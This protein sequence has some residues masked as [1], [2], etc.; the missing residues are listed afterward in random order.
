[1]EKLDHEYKVL[2]H[3]H[4]ESGGHHYPNGLTHKTFPNLVLE[5]CSPWIEQDFSNGVKQKLMR[6]TAGP[7]RDIHLSAPTTIVYQYHQRKQD[8]RKAVELAFHIR[9]L[10]GFCRLFHL[11]QN[12]MD[13]LV[14]ESSPSLKMLQLAE[15][16][17]EAS[18]FGDFQ[19][20]HWS[21]LAI[22]YKYVFL[23]EDRKQ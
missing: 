18:P 12:Y 15:K 7:V 23:K 5:A 21:P 6:F 4:K 10:S 16:V 14:S 17:F 13:D 11:G 20:G 3:L 8:V 9:Y 2:M 19:S 22:K 1:M